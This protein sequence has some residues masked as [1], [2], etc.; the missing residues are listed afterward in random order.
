MPPA[1]G[2]YTMDKVARMRGMDD[3]G[4]IPLQL[5][6]NRGQGVLEGL[7]EHVSHKILSFVP[8]DQSAFDMMFARP[9]DML[10]ASRKVMNAALHRGAP[11]PSF[12]AMEMV[13]K[14]CAIGINEQTYMRIKW[15]VAK[16]PWPA[17]TDFV[18]KKVEMQDVFYSLLDLT[19]AHVEE[20]G[21]NG[22]TRELVLSDVTVKLSYYCFNHVH[23]WIH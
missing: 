20:Y 22:R 13:V 10:Y 6:F 17:G 18:A 15:L 16:G 1:N 7:P 8:R 19:E 23:G 5:L 14:I 2:E 11:I 12:F 3:Q 4:D 21:L 9:V